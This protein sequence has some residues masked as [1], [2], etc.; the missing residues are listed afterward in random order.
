MF[1]LFHFTPPPYPP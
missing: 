1:D